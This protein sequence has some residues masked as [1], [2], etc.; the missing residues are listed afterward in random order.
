MRLE[1]QFNIGKKKRGV[2]RFEHC[3]QCLHQMGNALKGKRHVILQDN[4]KIHTSCYS[5]LYSNH[6][7]LRYIPNHPAHSCDLNPCEHVWAWLKKRISF[8]G[9]PSK[10]ALIRAIKEEFEK[11]P[12]R[13]IDKWVD[14]YWERMKICSERNGDWVGERECR[15]PRRE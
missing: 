13:T 15:K 7:K 3:H 11:I 10:D 14:S 6:L 12:Q 9:P 2:S 5:T 1:R 4:A 8:R